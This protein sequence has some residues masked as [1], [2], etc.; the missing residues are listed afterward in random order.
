MFITDNPLYDED[1]FFVYG[2]TSA[3]YDLLPV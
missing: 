1:L 3:I 2:I